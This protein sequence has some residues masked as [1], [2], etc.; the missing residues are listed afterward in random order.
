VMVSG[1]VISLMDIFTAIQED[2]HPK[3]QVLS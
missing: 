2:F 1:T 3:T